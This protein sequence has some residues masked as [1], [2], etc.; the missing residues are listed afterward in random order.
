MM[1]NSVAWVPVYFSEDSDP[2]SSY[3]DDC[4]LAGGCSVPE[5]NADPSLLSAKQVNLV[6][7]IQRVSL[8]GSI[9]LSFRIFLLE[10]SSRPG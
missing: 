3:V 10:F 4:S 5:N 9:H 2:V 1:L 8:S 7:F 6:F